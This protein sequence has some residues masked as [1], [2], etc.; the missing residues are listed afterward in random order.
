MPSIVGNTL[1][2]IMS[3]KVHPQARFSSTSDIATVNSEEVYLTDILFLNRDIRT[4]HS[5]WRATR[6]GPCS[7]LVLSGIDSGSDIDTLL[8]LVE[9]I[10]KKAAIV[11]G[12][13]QRRDLKLHLNMPLINM[14]IKGGQVANL[15]RHLLCVIMTSIDRSLIAHSVLP[16]IQE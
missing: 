12:K 5:T 11:L 16:R 10:P 6:P 7:I 1:R 15:F 13:F 2:R 3:A 14:D 8:K 4:F 9:N